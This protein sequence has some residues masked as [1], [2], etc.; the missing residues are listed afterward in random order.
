[1]VGLAQSTQTVQYLMR[2]PW[3]VLLAGNI[4]QKLIYINSFQWENTLN[5]LCCISDLSIG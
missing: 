1:L 3:L 5:Y 2:I 4:Q